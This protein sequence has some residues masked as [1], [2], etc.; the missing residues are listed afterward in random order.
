MIVGH[1]GQWQQFMTRSDNR[2]LSIMEMKQKYLKEQLMF[3]QSMSFQIQQQAKLAQ[4]AASG[5]KKRVLT[6]AD[7]CIQFTVDTT[8]SLWNTVNVGVNAD[9]NYTVTWGDGTTDTGLLQPETTT[10][11]H[12]YPENNQQYVTRMCFTNPEV[13]VYLDFPG[14]D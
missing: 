5:G 2:G 12:E 6:G 4:Q 13:V 3:E 10:V 9:T 1:P 7:G 8:H 11:E 14:N